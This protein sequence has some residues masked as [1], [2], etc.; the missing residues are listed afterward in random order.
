M[1]RTWC[2]VSVSLDSHPRI[3]KAGNLG[4]QVFEFA[5]RRNAELDRGGVIPAHHLDPEYLA[6][7]LMLAELDAR[8]GLE[9]CVRAGLLAPV[10]DGY[11]LCGWDDDWAKYPLSDA[12]RQR[13]S[14]ANRSSAARAP[15]PVASSAASPRARRAEPVA[16]ESIP[17][18]RK[19]MVEDPDVTRCHEP[20]VTE[21]DGHECHRSDQI[22]GEEI[23]SEIPPRELD[24]TLAPRDH[25]RDGAPT[26]A[27]DHAT[28]EPCHSK[29][30][31]YPQTDWHRRNAIWNAL[32]TSDEKVMR[33][34]IDPHGVG[35][36]RSCAGQNERNLADCMRQI[37]ESFGADQVEAKMRHVI[38]VYEDEAIGKRTRKWLRPAS[39]FNPKTILD[40]A[41]TPVGYWRQTNGH[42]KA[43]STRAAGAIEAQFERV[44]MLEA[45]EAKAS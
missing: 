7:V 35:L 30:Q 13:L 22:R 26:P 21:S 9:R 42:A 33:A 28:H 45:E 17:S 29:P 40:K 19:H 8:S 31:T 32:I 12:E 23:R 36:P 25:A 11:A 14:R 44:A 38:A 10:E 16:P 20:K 5:L 2:K 41:S 39:V 1:G 43:S 3:R 37:A 34:G 4:R 15:E 6:D 18:H 27:R 24:H